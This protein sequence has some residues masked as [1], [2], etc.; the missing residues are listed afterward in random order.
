MPPLSRRAPQPASLPSV[1]LPHNLLP[2]LQI[3]PPSL[4]HP[5]RTATTIAANT[6]S[7]PS[8]Y[9]RQH[10][11]PSPGVVAGAVLGSV[12]GFLFLLYLLYLALTSGRR[13]SASTIAGTSTTPSE[14]VD[15]GIRPRRR[16]GRGGGG[17]GAVIVEES[18]TAT[19]HSGLDDGG[20]VEV[21]EE[22]SVV[23]P[24][25]SSRSESRRHRHGRYRSRSRST[26]ESRAGGG[27]RGYRRVDPL[28]YGGG[29]SEFSGR[30]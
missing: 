29:D 28:A 19:S 4:P 16:R 5:K 13:F 22:E 8:T 2:R 1:D 18:V 30:S 6:I 27:G 24:P 17:G 14:I 25:P 15:V 21:I 23:D 12:A 11:S 9:G 26:S 10:S 3:N 7:I 20:V